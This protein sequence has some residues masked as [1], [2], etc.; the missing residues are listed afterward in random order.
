VAPQG[1]A[2]F[3]SAQSKAFIDELSDLR[4]GDDADP[5]TR[6]PHSS[7]SWQEK[8]LD[9]LR[10]LE[11]WDGSSE[12][13]EEDY[14]HQ[15]CL[16]YKMVLLITPAGAQADQA[17]FSYLKL[18]SQPK[19]ISESRIEWLW[20]VNDLIRRI[21]EKPADERMR[22]LNILSNS[23]NSVLQVYGDLAKASL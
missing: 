7:A 22:L 18:L 20:H 13:D 23:K 3:Q 12:S 19:P 21:N 9:Y 15:K 17:L 10:R 16:L 1:K 8:L 11:A 14:F 5:A 4:G 2:Y 6:E